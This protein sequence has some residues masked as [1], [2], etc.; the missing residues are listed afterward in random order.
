MMSS[1]MKNGGSTHIEQGTEPR[2]NPN[3]NEKRLAEERSER[4]TVQVSSGFKNQLNQIIYDKGIH[5][6]KLIASNQ[7]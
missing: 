6:Q 5:N 4:R 7:K 3:R 2:G 1:E